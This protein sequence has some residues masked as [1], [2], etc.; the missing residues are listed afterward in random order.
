M[1][2]RYDVN[3]IWK[4]I[5]VNESFIGTALYDICL[6]Q[7]KPRLGVEQRVSR[8]MPGRLSENGA[9]KNVLM[10]KRR[11]QTQLQGFAGFRHFLW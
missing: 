3:L 11:D 9:D 1:H 4:R 6:Y 5:L 8:N 2:V 10:H 7:W